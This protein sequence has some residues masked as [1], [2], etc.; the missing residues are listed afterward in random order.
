[1]KKILILLFTLCFLLLPQHARAATGLSVTPPVTEILIAPNKSLSTTVT[2]TNQGSDTDLLLSLHNVIPTDDHGHSTIDPR[3]LSLDGLPL[4]INPIGFAFDAPIHI[5][6][7]ASLPVSLEFQGANLDESQDVYFALLASPIK[8]TQ[9]PTETSISP[10]IAALFFTTITPLAAFPTDISLRDPHLPTLFNNSNNLSLELVAEN[11]TNIMLQVQ[12]KATLA[13]PQKK[14]VAESKFDPKLILGASSRNL[15]TFN[16]QPSLSSIGPYTLTIELSTIGGRVLTS[17]SYVIW[18]LPIKY[19]L[20]FV[21]VALLL[22]APYF[23]K[24]VLTKREI[25]A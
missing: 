10:A 24:I 7:G 23:Q 1:M 13:D 12:T 18:F 22:L 19:L 8:L 6:A 9:S 20:I 16:Y 5:S 4:V 2:L 17:H 3:P 11:K 14:V 25:K 21:G 15:A